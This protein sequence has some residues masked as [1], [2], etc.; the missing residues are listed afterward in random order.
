MLRML[1]LEPTALWDRQL[2]RLRLTRG[3]ASCWQHG[4]ASASEERRLETSP[5]GRCDPENAM[6]HW[7]NGLDQKLVSDLLNLMSC[8]ARVAPPRRVQLA[9]LYR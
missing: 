2:P 5:F 8:A 3:R 6:N 4:R 7:A 1:R 9:A